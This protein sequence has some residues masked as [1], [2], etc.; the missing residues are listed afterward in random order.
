MDISIF[1]Y[2]KIIPNEKYENSVIFILR[3]KLVN[4]SNFF[5]IGREKHVLLNSLNFLM[6]N[7]KHNIQF[8]HSSQK[9]SATL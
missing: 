5:L 7:S 4:L 2:L 9:N 8:L 6:Q 3:P 1:L